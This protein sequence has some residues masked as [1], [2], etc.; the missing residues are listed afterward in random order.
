M[1]SKVSK[2]F[3]LKA[4]IL[5]VLLLAAAVA[6]VIF[7]Y[8][9][10]LENA[11]E[12]RVYRL[13]E[14]SAKA[15]SVSIDERIASSFQQL[16]IIS[17][18]IDFKSDI[19]TNKETVEQLKKFIGISDFDNI[20]VASDN[21]VLLYQN[22]ST[23]DCSDRTYFKRAMAGEKCVE[24][25]SKGRLSGD[26]VF[27]FAQ[28][29]ITDNRV[30]GVIVATRNLKD[31]TRELVKIDK[32][33]NEFRFF[34][35]E[36]GEIVSVTENEEDM[37]S[38]GAYISDYFE[39]DKSDLTSPVTSVRRY[40]YDGKKYYGKY[41]PTGL[42]DIYI[43]SAADRSYASNLAGIYSKWNMVAVVSIFLLILCAAGIIIVYLKRRISEEVAYKAKQQ[44]A[45]EQYHEVY[46]K[47]SLERS[48]IRGSFHLNLTKNI[49]TGIKS[50]ESGFEEFEGECGADLVLEKICT[51]IH[52]CDRD[53]FRKYM[54][55]KALKAAF[56]NGKASVEKEFLAYSASK[57]YA[58]VE[59]IADLVSDPVSGD[60]EAFVYA[61]GINEKRRLEQ[62]GKKIINEDFAA[63]GLIDVVSKTV[64]GIKTLDSKDVLKDY[65]LR[66]GVCYDEVSE[67]TLRTLLS[68][69]D[70]ND[71]KENI[72]LS[73]VLEKLENNLSYSITISI[74]SEEEKSVSY[75]K[76][77]Y[78]YLDFRKES[79]VVS[80]ENI[81]DILSGKM[82]V[83]TG[84]YNS[85]GFYEKVNLWIKNNP[86]KKYRMQRY[87]I[88]GF[89]N[90]NGTY[91]YE[92]GN[93]LLRDIG[94]YMKKNNNENS[95][96]AHLSSDHFA[97]F[98]EEGTMSAEESYK[99][100][101]KDFENYPLKYPISIH[102]GVYDLC[103]P[104]CD[105]YTM[106]Y[107]AHIALRSVKK[108][109]S[110]YI[111]Y[112][113][114]GLLQFTREQQ[115][116]LSEVETAIR[117]QQFE[118]WFQPQVN[119]EN[120]CIV[121]VEALIR[122]RHPSK[123]LIM[124]SEFIALLESSRQIA[125]IDKYVLEKCCEY[126]NRWKNEGILMPISVNMSRIDICD[127]KMYQTFLNILQK[128]DVSPKMIRL[129]ITESAYIKD[130]KA[131]IEAVKR[132]KK[133]GFVI[134]M[135]DFGSGYSS[136]NILKDLDIDIL[137]LDMFL[138]SQIGSGDEKSD[139]I[140]RSVVQMA[141]LLNIAIIA[142]GVETKEQAEYLKAMDCLNMQGYYFEKPMTADK[143]GELIKNTKI[144]ELR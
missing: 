8:G 75:Y 126:I 59:I 84:L 94:K 115:L 12:Q 141:H 28:P 131:L 31:I 35:Y 3:I 73:N 78:S 52:P 122:W 106:S 120:G 5:P 113:K 87:N 46:N 93:M 116:M 26:T 139:N 140:L 13:L 108:D 107:K 132:F 41:T 37:F 39:L 100:F 44:K 143:F 20:A 30:E 58:W 101:L 33:E 56:E 16:N 23:A 65:D 34:C 15:K 105:S 4:V 109:L 43:F 86:G 144:G 112:Y 14:D 64:Y 128:Y 53:E 117:E 103:E 127:E 137:K 114:K 69:S 6:A 88:D 96:A 67:K 70:F 77:S 61:N 72:K 89:S 85:S 11:A 133:A 76:I 63:M 32:A 45:L 90:I 135:D 17:S 24:F 27:V 22:A 1:N 54:L 62:I 130:T 49:C 104:D 118:V 119:Y 2:N 79:I 110:K 47:R 19:Y 136:L 123:G 129:E 95:F 124:P 111:A 71:I 99:M 29:V 57:K 7:I 68:K 92:A 10:K 21:G 80:C 42:D 66:A 40:M 25:L 142:E 91:G 82:D 38:P 50:S 81:T 74:A 121:G 83:L 98:C 134:E 138:I 102:M 97:R 60:L 48:N 51:I 125:L 55:P 36:D 18:N 9:I